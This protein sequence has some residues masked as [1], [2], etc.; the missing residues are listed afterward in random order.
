L[1]VRQRLVAARNACA[2]AFLWC[3]SRLSP[4]RVVPLDLV[5]AIRKL[6]SGEDPL[7][8]YIAA[9]PTASLAGP[10]WRHLHGLD[11]GTWSLG[12]KSLELLQTLVSIQRPALAIEFGS[13]ISTAVIAMAM[14]EAGASLSD[15]ILLSFEQDEAEAERTRELLA[16][17]GLAEQ[18]R[19]VVAPLTRL[20]IEGVVTTCYDVPDD[21]GAVFV[22]RKA[23]FVLIDGPA[24][25][26][27]IRFGT[28]PLARPFVSPHARFVLDDA[29][30]DGELS[31]ARR[32]RDLPYIRVA[33][34]C[35]LE[36]GLL[37]GD[38]VGAPAS[39]AR[40]TKAI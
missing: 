39:P 21:I 20:T 13:G 17:V 15:L 8:P 19:V 33:G 29:L 11:I 7:V 3:T 27:G 36:K 5:V 24:G 23:D 28:L 14:R 35:L 22:E 12:P 26:P 16:G 9:T 4:D 1:R 18:V 6:G 10:L 2:R 32:W 40:P 34:V 31:I 38:V 25:E 37:I 30:R